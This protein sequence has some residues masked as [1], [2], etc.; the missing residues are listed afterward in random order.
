MGVTAT[1]LLGGAGELYHGAFGAV[2]PLDTAVGADLAP[3]VW[4]DFGGTDGGVT[5]NVDRNFYDL[6]ADQIMDPAG[7]RQTS[8]LTTIATNLAEVTL[9]NLAVAWGEDPEAI[10]SGGTGGTAWKA[11]EQQMDDSG[12]EPRYH[13]LIFRGWAPGRKRRLVIARKVLSV[14]AVGT[15]YKKDEQTFIPVQFKCF[16]VSPSIKPL[17]VVEQAG[18]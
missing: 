3:E 18:A 10:T 12:E 13:A 9:E 11:L 14:N 17:R 2:E 16:Y 5:K 15:A 6:R 4:T 8:R 7:T 1:N